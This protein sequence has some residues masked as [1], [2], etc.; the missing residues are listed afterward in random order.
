M[1]PQIVCPDAAWQ[2]PTA[3]GLAVVFADSSTGWQLSADGST[4]TALDGAAV[5]ERLTHVSQG[6]YCALDGTVVNGAP[7][8]YLDAVPPSVVCFPFPTFGKGN[9]GGAP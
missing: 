6:Q 7:V 2:L 3:V 5:K 1:G 9:A 8:P 4:I